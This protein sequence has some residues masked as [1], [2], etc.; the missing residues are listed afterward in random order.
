MT[1]SFSGG[2]HDDANPPRIGNGYRFFHPQLNIPLRSQGELAV[3][4][5]ACDSKTTPAREMSLAWARE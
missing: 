5:E 3:I 2:W 4:R 1:I